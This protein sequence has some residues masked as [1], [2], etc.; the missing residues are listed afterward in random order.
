MSSLF[1]S[2]DPNADLPPSTYIPYI[3]Q[4]SPQLAAVLAAETGLGLLPWELK[5]FL[6]ELDLGD[7]DVISADRFCGIYTFLVSRPPTPQ[8]AAVAEPEKEV[9]TQVS[10]RQET[11]SDHVA[12]SEPVTSPSTEQTVTITFPPEFVCDPTGRVATE[13]V[14]WEGSASLDSATWRTPDGAGQ[15]ALFPFLGASKSPLAHTVSSHKES[16]LL[17]GALVPWRNSLAELHV[18]GDADAFVQHPNDVSG[19][20][21]AFHQLLRVELGI[22]NAATEKGAGWWRCDKSAYL[23]LQTVYGTNEEETSAIRLGDGMID[24]E[25]VIKQSDMCKRLSTDHGASTSANAA[26]ALLRVFAKNHN[27]IVERVKE[28]IGNEAEK[29]DADTLFQIA[30]HCNANSL[31]S[32]VLKDYLPFL[33]A[34][35]HVVEVDDSSDDNSTRRQ[36]GACVSIELDLLMRVVAAMAPEEKLENLKGENTLQIEDP[37]DALVTASSSK[38]GLAA[39]RTLPQ[40][41]FNSEAATVRRAR[42]A[43]VCTLNEFRV[44][45]GLDKWSDFDSM[46]ADES[47]LSSTLDSLYNSDVD[48]VELYTGMLCEMNVVDAGGCLPH[49]VKHSVGLLIRELI[50][51]DLFF[52]KA[53]REDEELLTEVGARLGKSATLTSLLEKHANVTV[54]GVSVFEVGALVSKGEE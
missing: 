5:L 38:C 14:R 25:A 15:C 45:C 41:F 13:T 27:E 46:T 32:I 11:P 6:K 8:V 39:R 44:K 52:K 49:T 53:T 29:F 4:H 2:L 17:G 48:T 16:N 21:H 1:P 50:D 31:R 36:S 47:V 23:D 42:T 33:N 54:R 26:S 51:G 9:S 12:P 34:G 20:L 40:R 37:V 28:S 24:V 19:V 7:D 18:R 22:D 10:T 43:G 3:P 30:R 35:Q